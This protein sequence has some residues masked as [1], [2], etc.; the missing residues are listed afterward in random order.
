MSARTA[1]PAIAVFL[2]GTLLVAACGIRPRS[3]SVPDAS[4]GTV[5][6]AEEIAATEA[7]TMWEALRR[8]VRYATFG[9]SATGDPVRV[10][11]R[12]FS[13]ISLS[14]DMPIYIDRIQVR[15]IRVLDGMP[16]TDIDRIQ[17]LSGVDATTYYGTNAGDGVI[18]IRTRRGG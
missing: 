11:R 7:T 17:V 5:I 12:G 3:T 13:S 18:L 4:A 15:D 8:T 9:E 6:T 14:E 16:A 2:A 1:A 10:H